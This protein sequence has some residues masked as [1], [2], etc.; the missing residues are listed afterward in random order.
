MNTSRISRENSLLMSEID[1]KSIEKAQQLLKRVLNLLVEAIGRDPLLA[2]EVTRLFETNGVATK[3]NNRRKEKMPPIDAIAVLE[4][5]GVD[6]LTAELNVLKTDE[7]HAVARN[8]GI[9][10]A[11][12]L[13]ENRPALI[14]NILR[15]AQSRL[16][17]GSSFMK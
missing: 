9:R 17:Q 4:R 6:G 14:D 12:K 3:S 10:I 15:V 8:Q 11:A 5:A 2:S 13:K 16:G 1:S 7:I